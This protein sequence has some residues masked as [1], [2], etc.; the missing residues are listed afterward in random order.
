MRHFLQLSI[1]WLVRYWVFF[2]RLT[3]LVRLQWYH[4]LYRL[5]HLPLFRPLLFR[6]CML[7]D[8]YG[9]NPFLGLEFRLDIPEP[10]GGIGAIPEDLKTW[11]ENVIRFQ[12]EN[13]QGK[14]TCVSLTWNASIQN[15]QIERFKCTY[16]MFETFSFLSLLSGKIKRISPFITLTKKP[17]KTRF[18][19]F[20]AGYFW[21]HWLPLRASSPSSWPGW[22]SQH[23][24]LLPVS[25]TLAL[26]VMCGAGM[27]E[28]TATLDW[29]GL[30]QSPILFCLGRLQVLVTQLSVLLLI[31]VWSWL[32]LAETWRVS[33]GL[34]SDWLLTSLLRLLSLDLS[35]GAG[36]LPLGLGIPLTPLLATE[37]TLSLDW[38]WLWLAVRLEWPF[39][40]P[41]WLPPLV[42]L[43]CPVWLPLWLPPLVSLTCPLWLVVPPLV[44]L[45]CPLWLW[46]PPLVRLACPLWLA[47]LEMFVC[48]KLMPLFDLL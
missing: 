42:R 9:E 25:V 35:G 41:F 17:L 26:L 40:L 22:V 15:L 48:F 33:A 44:R 47:P 13:V 23:C 46:L 29:L 7:C 37:V 28:T 5:S 39:W 30:L 6:V 34:S 27:G 19:H 32:V 2:T 36:G 24:F 20:V 8:S 11:I 16:Y 43:A 38:L 3:R 18:L 10:R 31:S 45:I 21:R 12:L 14:V 1:L 4:W